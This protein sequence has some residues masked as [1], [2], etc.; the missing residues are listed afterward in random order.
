MRK[1]FIFLMTLIYLVIPMSIE[2]QYLIDQTYYTPQ[3]FSNK[4]ENVNL[5]LTN[6]CT[7]QGEKHTGLANGKPISVNYYGTLTTPAGD[8][9]ISAETG[10]G[11][12]ANFNPTGWICYISAGGDVYSQ[13]YQN[14]NCVSSSKEHRS[15]TLD[16]PYIRIHT[17]SSSGGYVSTPDYSGG[18][19]SGSSSEGSSYNRHEATCRGCNGSG[20]CQHCKG[21]G[22]VN[23]YKSKCSLCHGTGKCVSCGG[24]GKIHGNF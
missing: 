11:F 13:R 23:N 8:R 7:F 22:Y 24:Q 2:A 14:G 1:A 17:E 10:T 20:L 16:G 9:Y 6:G 21:S 5:Y 19:N 3:T 12:D 15:Y 4:T 18:Y